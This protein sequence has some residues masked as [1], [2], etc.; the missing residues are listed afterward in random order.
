MN[1][2]RATV[3]IV[4]FFSLFSKV[5]PFDLSVSRAFVTTVLAVVNCTVG[6]AIIV[7]SHLHRGLNL[8]PGHSLTSRIGVSLGAALDHAFSASLSALAMLL[9]VLVFNNRA[10][11]KFMFT[12]AIN[13]VR[14]IFSA[15]FITIPVTCSVRGGTR[16]GHVSGRGGW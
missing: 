13:M 6:S 5:L 7:F 8:C 1:L 15:L 11:H 9:T 3:V 16:T 2:T 12:L 4:K 14:N 10:V